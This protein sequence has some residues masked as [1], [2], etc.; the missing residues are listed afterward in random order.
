MLY[1]VAHVSV[2]KML[3]ENKA[4]VNLQEED[5]WSPLMVASQNGHI[6]VVQM[7]IEINLQ[8]KNR[9]SPLMF[10][11]LNDHIDVLNMLQDRPFN[12]S[13]VCPGS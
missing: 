10:A 4:M 2:V 7:L 9:V 5:G 11:R 3:I 1:N 6:D 13:I 12:L 8:N